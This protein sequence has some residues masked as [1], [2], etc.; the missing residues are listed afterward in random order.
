MFIASWLLLPESWI[1]RNTWKLFIVY[2]Y[3]RRWLIAHNTRCVPI[4]LWVTIMCRSYSRDREWW[5][6]GSYSSVYIC[7]TTQSSLDEHI[8]SVPTCT[9]SQALFC[10]QCSLLKGV[11]SLVKVCNICLSVTLATIF[12]WNLSHLWPH[13]TPNSSSC[14]NTLPPISRTSPAM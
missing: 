2:I 1:S 3:K 11:H 10:M 12:F 8:R 9:W 5:S 7:T 14:I 13:I 6:A 4:N